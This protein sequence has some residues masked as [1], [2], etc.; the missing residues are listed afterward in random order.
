M[1]RQ[2][3][4]VTNEASAEAVSD[5][6]VECGAVSVSLQDAGHEPLFE[7]K[8]GDMPVW[9]RTKVI[10]L[11]PEDAD[12]AQ[13]LAELQS[14]FGGD[15]GDWEIEV[16][17]DRPWE[18]VW[19][20]H[21]R[22]FQYGRRLWIC[23]TGFHA[24]EATGIEVTLDPGLA[25]GTGTHPTTAL[26][27]EWLDGETLAEKSVIDY[28]CGSGILGVAALVLGAGS[29]QAV[30][31]DPQALRATMDNAKKNRVEARLRCYR[32]EQLGSGEADVLLANILANPLVELAHDLRRRI[33]LGGHLILS[34]VLTEQAQY[35]CDAYRAWFD[36]VAVTEREGWVRLDAVRR[37]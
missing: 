27:L 6:L 8:P 19:L 16:L 36:F 17:E 22:P 24:P 25:F 29:V 9:T 10:G 13:I 35:V 23:P 37:S 32:P 30:D 14:R 15:P 26:C 11:Y 2:L 28:G 7:P 33:K 34:G 3:A 12:L 5:A 20:E 18:R 31:I 1:W 21:F 4:V